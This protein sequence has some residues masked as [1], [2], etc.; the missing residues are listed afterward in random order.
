MPRVHFKLGFYL[1][2]EQL[3]DTVIIVLNMTEPIAVDIA[4]RTPKG[5]VTEHII[6]S[7]GGDIV[8]GSLTW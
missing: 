5:T 4:G 3:F 2:S 1:L 6:L 8:E 7:G